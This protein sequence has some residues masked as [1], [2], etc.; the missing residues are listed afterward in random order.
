MF[1]GID[2]AF[3]AKKRLPAAL[4]FP[5][6]NN[7]TLMEIRSFDK[8]F[9]PP[10]G[11]GLRSLFDNDF[12][13]IQLQKLDDWLEK[14]MAEYSL[15]SIAIDCPTLF[16]PPD[17]KIRASEQ[18]IKKV[19]CGIF[20]TPQQHSLERKIEAAKTI[21]SQNPN[22][23][24]SGFSIWMQF[25]IEFA[26]LCKSKTQTIE[27]FPNYFWKSNLGKNHKQIHNNATVKM[28]LLRKKG[29][30]N[31]EKALIFCTGMPE[32]QI[33]AAYCALTASFLT[34]DNKVGFFGNEDDK[35][36]YLK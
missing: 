14:I 22:K 12:K 18:Q 6:G 33:D 29:L 5:S 32:D 1:L 31:A 25:A 20:L 3:S 28:E 21:L 10:F 23:M 30:V 17:L 8:K 2:F 7:S 34:V 15:T 9:L 24:H 11:G 26:E 13:S 4:L 16:C 36:Y 19:G 27:V 35:I